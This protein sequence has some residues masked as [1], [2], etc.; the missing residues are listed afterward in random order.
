MSKKLLII[1][2]SARKNGYT[3]RL[4]DYVADALKGYEITE[5]DT[6]SH[7]FSP[8]NGCNYCESKGRCVHNDL[9]EFFEA[10]SQADLIVFA[11]PV[12][13]GTFSA[14][15]KSLIDRFQVFYTGFYADGKV[16]KISKPRQA[17]FIA[18]SGRGGE[19]AFDY[20]KSQLECAFT[21]LN[22]TL[23]KATLCAY[24]DT[25]PRFNEA[26]ADLK[27]ELSDE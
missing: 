2:G 25:E 6:Y 10:F 26:L 5:F 14:P 20:M 13:N 12:Y 22:M 3:N 19:N 15:L 9:D 8:C 24:T 7:P 4:A 27:K 1:R 23:R 16:Q 18:A 21:I 11:S 17:I